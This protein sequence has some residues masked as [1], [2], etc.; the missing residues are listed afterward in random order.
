VARDATSIVISFA[1]C[2]ETNEPCGL[3]KERVILANADVLA[4]HDSR[5]TL[6]DDDLAYADF[7]AICA[8][9]SKVFWVR[10]S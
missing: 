9:N 7:L 6:P 1:C 8:L 3:R 10:I 2:T 4:C 5:A